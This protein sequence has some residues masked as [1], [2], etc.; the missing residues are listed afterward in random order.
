[1]AFFSSG[2]ARSSSVN[3]KREEGR[4]LAASPSRKVS[5]RLRR[6]FFAWHRSTWPAASSMTRPAV[7]AASWSGE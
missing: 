6:A 4:S 1:M 5:R 7:P 3:C 2:A